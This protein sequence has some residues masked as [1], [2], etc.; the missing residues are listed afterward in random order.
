MYFVIGEVWRS[1]TGGTHDLPLVPFCLEFTQSL[2]HRLACRDLK[3]CL[4]SIPSFILFKVKVP[5]DEITLRRCFNFKKLRLRSSFA[6]TI[7]KTWQQVDASP[8]S[9]LFVAHYSVTQT[10]LL[11]AKVYQGQGSVNF[12]GVKLLRGTICSQLVA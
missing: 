12:K 6:E 7:L 5:V 1:W 2:L 11:F 4:V 10:L 9:C 3:I 8:E